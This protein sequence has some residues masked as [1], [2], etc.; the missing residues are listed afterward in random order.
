M[1]FDLSGPWKVKLDPQNCGET[2]AWYAA[3]LETDVSADLPGTVAEAGLGDVPDLETQWTGSIY[4]RSWFHEPEL[5]SYR[6]TKP[7][8]F[9]FWLTPLR[10]YVGVAWYE[11]EVEIPESCVGRSFVIELERPHWQTSLWIDGEL[12]GSGES[13]SVPHYVEH[14]G[15]KAP[16]RHR[17]TLRVDNAI[18]EI[19]PGQ[20]A[21]SISDHTQ[22]NWNGV[23]GQMQLRFVNA[24]EIQSVQLRPDWQRNRLCVR[25][26]LTCEQAIR[27]SLSVKLQPAGKPTS[28]VRSVQASVATQAMDH[29]F[30]LE[31]D[32]EGVERWDE[33]HP[34]LHEVSIVFRSSSGVEVVWCEQHGFRDFGVRGTRFAVNARALF[35]RGNVDCCVFPKTGYPPMDVE[36]WMRYFRIL[37][38]QGF[39]HVRFHSWCPPEAA[40][41]A[42]DQCGFYLQ[43]EAPTW[44]NHGV[45]IGQGDPIDGFIYRETERLLEQY[46]N[47]ASLC[48]VAS[49]NEPFGARQVS[50]LAEYVRHFR[51][52]DDRQLYTGASVGTKWPM[53]RESDFIVHSKP[54]GL[55]FEAERP[56]SLFD[57]REQIAGHAQPF[58]SHEMGQFCVFPDFEEIAQYSGLL[59]AK[60]LE[61]FREC[62]LQQ[63]DAA[64]ARRFLQASGQLQLLCYRAEV[65]AALRTP[66]LA[67]IQ[68]LGANDFPGQGTAL[69]GWLNAFYERKPYVDTGAVRRWLGPVTILARTPGFVG[70]E[71]ETLWWEIEVANFSDADLTLAL[72]EW[73]LVE[74]GTDGDQRIEAG[75]F[76]CP[77]I[78]CGSVS[79]LGRVSHTLTQISSA[80]KWMFRV[81]VADISNEWP[82]WVFPRPNALNIPDTIHIAHTWDIALQHALDEGKD[83]LV[84][85]ADAIQNG[86]EVAQYFRPAF[87]NTSWFQMAPPH[88]LGLHIDPTHPVFDGF[89]TEDHSDYQWWELVQDQPVANLEF[90]PKEL[91][92]IVQPIDTWFI[93]RKLGLLFEFR[94]GKSR[95]MVCTAKLDAE[96]PSR[97]VAAQLYRSLIHYMSGAHFQPRLSVQASVLAEL[98]E[99][100]A[101]KQYDVG[102]DEKPEELIPELPAEAP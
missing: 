25:G 58:V 21:H 91:Q 16:G 29:R 9:P 61:M 32:L 97:P 5:E 6:N 86:R 46:G 19:H 62:F 82:L 12:L 99:C 15:L 57:Y 51:E 85:A 70:C 1:K 87:W 8:H 36:A 24:V 102:T 88:T 34:I 100:K 63:F 39:N 72:L 64:T 94:I 33:F 69:V 75:S 40:F 84:L 30:E 83:V 38:E 96:D 17:L 42:A 22:G 80:R 78:P 92:P 71:G 65:E 14:A 66:G 52:R 26:L 28:A 90:F 47:H 43:V 4:D 31:L 45:S 76:I 89:P 81:R 79:F 59:K 73:E 55:P 60:N 93:N 18:R 67:G 2:E 101:R 7:P 20:D 37:G 56:H 95:V 54:R 74:C 44:P 3:P 50:F 77:E 10:R 53:V 49:G 23:I 68:L 35:L 11:R 13:L 41:A 48:M 27:G 98:F